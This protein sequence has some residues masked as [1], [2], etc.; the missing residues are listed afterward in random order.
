M[1]YT[2]GLIIGNL[3]VLVLGFVLGAMYV[4]WPEKKP[5][6]PYDPDPERWIEPTPPQ[7]PQWFYGPPP[8]VG[9]WPASWTQYERALRW[10]DG[11]Y[12]SVSSLD[13]NDEHQAAYYAS[14]KA[15]NQVHIQWTHRPDDW[16]AHSYT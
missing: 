12:W 11:E 15:E 13:V 3:I 7:K 16:P 14:K 10:W 1:E 4:S 2:L 9:W 5:V 8:S 6:T